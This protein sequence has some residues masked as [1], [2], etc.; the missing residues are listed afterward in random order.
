MRFDAMA[1]M[2]CLLLATTCRAQ[3]RVDAPGTSGVA[4]IGSLVRGHVYPL[5]FL[6]SSPY[7]DLSFPGMQQ[8]SSVTGTFLFDTGANVSGVDGRW[9]SKGVHWRQGALAT[10]AGTTGVL[11]AQTAVLD[12]L[13]LGSGYFVSPT[14]LVEDF[15]HFISPTGKTQVGLLGTDFI[16]RYAITLDYAKGQ[17]TVALQSEVGPAPSSEPVPVTYPFR[18]PTATVNLG[19]A[20]IACRID[21]GNSYQD[22]RPLLDVNQAAVTALNA[23]GILLS[24]TGYITVAGVTGQQDLALLE[25]D[26]GLSLT[27]GSVTLSDVVLVYHDQ[28]TLAQESS[29][30]VLA[31]SSLLSRFGRFTLDPFAGKLWIGD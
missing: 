2:V 16:S 9:L 1:P 5:T 7:I 22:T 15:T 28:G 14:F 18:L 29:P 25:A 30:L 10:V 19:G 20:S 26:G 11:R 31:G 17:V 27:I 8:G 4:N 6:D 3:D 13:S 12:S 21:T 24:A 23:A